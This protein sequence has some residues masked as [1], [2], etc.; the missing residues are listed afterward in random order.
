MLAIVVDD[1]HNKLLSSSSPGEKL[2]C[3]ISAAVLY[4]YSLRS[5]DG[6]GEGH[7]TEVV[8]QHLG[9]KQNIVCSDG[10]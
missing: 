9:I 10:R 2:I 7:S 8:R 4:C 6:P 1:Q 3:D 5:C